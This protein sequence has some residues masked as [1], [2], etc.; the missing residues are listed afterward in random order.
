M[1]RDEM[2]LLMPGT[3]SVLDHPRVQADPLLTKA[4]EDC[5][6][7]DVFETL[8]TKVL[9]FYFGVYCGVIGALLKE[10]EAL[11]KERDQWLTQQ[12]RH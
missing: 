1:T 3:A 10:V 4:I 8:S 7:L 12:P 2:R 11:H 6:D 9:S 5:A